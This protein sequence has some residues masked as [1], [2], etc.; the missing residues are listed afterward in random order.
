MAIVGLE[1]ERE[2]YIYIYRY[3]SIYLADVSDIF[4][5]FLCS[6][7][8]KGESEGAGRE[9]RFFIENPTRGGGS[10]GGAEGSGGC[11]RRIGDF[12]GGGG[13]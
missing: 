4:Y 6:G 7:T 11:L 13:G 8:G 2:I 10:L 9:G 1:K 12:L 3:I 5:F